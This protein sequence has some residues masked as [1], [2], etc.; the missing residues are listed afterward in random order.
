VP[1]FRAPRQ[2]APV[3]T[4]HSSEKIPPMIRMLERIKGNVLGLETSGRITAADIEGLTPVLDEAIPG[5]V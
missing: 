3:P 2:P 4:N 5:T 1:T